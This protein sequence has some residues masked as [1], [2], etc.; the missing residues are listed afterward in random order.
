MSMTNGGM[1]INSRFPIKLRSMLWLQLL[2]TAMLLVGTAAASYAAEVSLAWNVSSGPVAGYK[3]YYSET[4]GS[5]GDPVDV[6]NTTSCTIK[7]LSPDTTYY[8]VVK[9]YDASGNLSAPSNELVCNSISASA[10]GNGTLTP[11]GTLFV[12]SEDSQTYTITPAAGYHIADVLVDSKSV[13]AVTS[14]TFSNVAAA[15][16]IAAQFTADI[17]NYSIQAS[18]DSGGSVS[19]SGTTT[20]DAGG[21]AS[22]TIT[23]QSNYQVADVTV[24]GKSVGAVSSYTFSNVAGNHTIAAQFKPKTFT[25]TA[26][27]QA[28][29]AISPSGKVAV[30]GGGNASFNVT[31]AEN[32]KIADVVVDGTSEGARSSYSFSNVTANHSISATFAPITYTITASAGDHG[33]ISPA[34]AVSVDSGTNMAFSIYPDD[35]YQVDQVLVDGKSIGSDVTDYLFSNVVAD[36]SISATFKAKN[37]P[38]VAD[39]GP[40]QKVTEGAAVALNGSNS[41]DPDDGIASYQWTQVSGAKVQ[42]VNP[43]AANASF[44]APYVNSDSEALVFKLTVIDKSGLESS[45]TCIVNVSWANEPPVPDAGPD[46]SVAEGN[47]VLLDGSNSTDTDGSIAAYHWQQIPGSG[48]GVQLTN[49]DTAQASFTAPSVGDDGASLTFQ[50][51]ITDNGGLQRTATCIVQVTQA[52]LPPVASAGKDHDATPSQ[53]V[54][55]NGSGSSDHEGSP[56]TYRWHQIYGPPVTLSNPTAAKPTFVAPDPGNTAADLEFILTVTDS[57]G[58]QAASTCTVHVGAPLPNLSGQFTNTSAFKW[59]WQSWVYGTL[60]VTNTGAAQ[61]GSSQVSFYLSSDGSTLG[62]YLGSRNVSSVLAGQTTSVYFFY[63]LGSGSSS[64]WKYLIAVIDPG[65]QVAEAN[66]TDNKVVKRIF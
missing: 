59:F 41:T 27:A 6:G 33:T 2:L 4:S 48:P 38:P 58:L 65:G 55:L 18:A 57:V 37:M 25:I 13:G 56:L 35:K 66:K 64:Y 36:H 8:L 19:P 50:L 24:D 23:P 51:T 49:A 21:N 46:Q 53:T 9:A 10:G 22:F 3:V 39:A 52:Y 26:S 15:H 54:T 62:K 44:T 45:D 34:G 40:D 17:V 7:N 60:Q 47:T 5:Y 30:S 20:V 32:Y 42:L 63:S 14:Y 11:D 43:T 28:H 12:S 61:A 16:T 31:P 1:L 29:G